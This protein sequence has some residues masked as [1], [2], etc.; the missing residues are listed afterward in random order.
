MVELPE[1]QRAAALRAVAEIGTR[2]TEL[3]AEADRLQA[4]LRKAAVE[5]ARI[6]AQRTRIRELAGVSSKTLYSW[7]DEAGIDVRVTTRRGR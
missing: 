3:L 5:A 7:L 4:D 6:G 2:R 1:E